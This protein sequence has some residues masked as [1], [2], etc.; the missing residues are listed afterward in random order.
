MTGWLKE[1]LNLLQ[2]CSFSF[3]NN[4][5]KLSQSLDNDSKDGIQ[6]RFR[7]Q[8]FSVFI[9]LVKRETQVNLTHT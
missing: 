9:V 1:N 2:L 6:V 8:F 3:S 4:G 5:P 7:Q